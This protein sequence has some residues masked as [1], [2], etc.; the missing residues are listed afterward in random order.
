[1][2][3][4]SPSYLPA[5]HA[6]GSITAMV[7]AEPYRVGDAALL[8]LT[9]PRGFASTLEVGRYFLA[10]CAEA[11]TPDARVDWSIYLRVPLFFESHCATSPAVPDYPTTPPPESPPAESPLESIRVLLP[12]TNQR[13]GQWLIAQPVGS[14]LHL[15]G[16][17]GRAAMPGDN[18]RALLIACEPHLLPLFLP[19]AHS[20]LDRSGRVSLLLPPGAASDEVL[21]LCP[22]DVEIHIPPDSE[23]WKS[24]A[25]ELL[26]WCDHLCATLV[27]NEAVSA[28]NWIDTIHAARFTLEPG[29]ADFYTPVDI[30][31]ATGA[32]YACSVPR[33]NGQ[34]TRACVHGPILDLARLA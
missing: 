24:N 18:V 20:V 16:P 17:F 29:F 27:G 19:A 8:T 32:C 13:G 5:I 33:R 21:P 22:L 30:I 11:T 31:C 4:P 34:Q 12:D 3:L 9:A 28:D 26:R 23:T 6:D 10:R 25:G 15:L 2:S 1:M 14:T 7:S